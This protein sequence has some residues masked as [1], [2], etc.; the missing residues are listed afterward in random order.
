KNVSLFTLLNTINSIASQE[1]RVLIIITNHI[2]RLNKV[3][4]RP[5]RVDK[6]VELRLVNSNIIAAL[7]CLVFK[8]VEVDVTLLENT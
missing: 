2:K 7:F 1:G 3:L 8:P 4:I 6:K 5:G